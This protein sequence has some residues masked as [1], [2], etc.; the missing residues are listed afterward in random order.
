MNTALTACLSDVKFAYIRAYQ[1]PTF[2]DTELA[3]LVRQH[4][5]RE[6]LLLRKA[7]SLPCEIELIV[8]LAVHF[9]CRYHEVLALMIDDYQTNR[10]A[11]ERH[12]SGYYPDYLP[13]TC[14]VQPCAH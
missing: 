4:Y 7:H 2:T 11:F 12:Q 13:S 8:R 1:L 3:S 5:R 10:P 14:A 9:K 6:D